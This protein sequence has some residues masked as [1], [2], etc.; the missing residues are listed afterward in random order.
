MK[1]TA[2]VSL[3]FLAAGGACQTSGCGKPVPKI[4]EPG[5]SKNLV[6]ESASGTTPREYRI[7][8]PE[9]Y[10]PD[11]PVPIILSFHGRGSD[12][13]DQDQL[14]GFSNQSYG[15]EGIAVYPQGVPV[16]AVHV[17]S[18]NERAATKPNIVEQG[19]PRQAIARRSRR[20]H[21]HQRCR[22]HPR[23]HRPPFGP[24]LH[25]SISRVRVRKIKRGRLH[26]DSCL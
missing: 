1:S 15:F 20:R 8:V 22:F 5:T 6:I 2:L 25:R 17:Q 11:V 16:S 19:Y 9:S 21:Q 7:Y 14:S 13:E 12:M 18:P 23:T 4:V 3:G 24:L 10:N 26:R